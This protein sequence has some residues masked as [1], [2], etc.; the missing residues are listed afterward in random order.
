MVGRIRPPRGPSPGMGPCS[1]AASR[2]AVEA[3]ALAPL[4][5]RG[6]LPEYETL[7]PLPSRS[8]REGERESG[9]GEGAGEVKKSDV[10]IP[11]AG[12]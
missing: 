6:P 9:E 1:S 2:P 4:P 3:W 5:R 10:W 7:A 12:S 8:I 11:R